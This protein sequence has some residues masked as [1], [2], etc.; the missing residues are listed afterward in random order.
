MLTRFIKETLRNMITVVLD[1][2]DIKRII[3]FL[4]S[5]LSSDCELRDDFLDTIFADTEDM[6]RN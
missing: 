2:S 3:R 6:E 4:C 1:D 5:C